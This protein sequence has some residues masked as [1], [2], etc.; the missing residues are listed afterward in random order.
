MLLSLIL[1][2]G[3]HLNLWGIKAK[4]PHH[5]GLCLIAFISRVK[6]IHWSLITCGCLHTTSSLDSREPGG[7]FYI[8]QEAINKKVTE[9][10]SWEE[11]ERFFLL[12]QFVHV[13][14]DWLNRHE[15]SSWKETFGFYIHLSCIVTMILKMKVNWNFLLIENS[16]FLPK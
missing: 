10:S 7:G 16:F 14:W 6:I 4:Q 12:W 5:E 11:T 3:V 8:P 2:G 13:F 1:E 9:W 15:V